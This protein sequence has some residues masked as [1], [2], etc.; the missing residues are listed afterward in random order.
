MPNKGSKFAAALPA[1]TGQLNRLF[2]CRFCQGLVVL[3]SS[4]L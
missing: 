3:C 1:S 2:G 4:E